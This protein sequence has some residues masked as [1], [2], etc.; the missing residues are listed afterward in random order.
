MAPNSSAMRVALVLQFSYIGMSIFWN[1]IGIGLF[2]AGMKPLGPVA[3]GQT[4]FLLSAIGLVLWIG[5]QKS[6]WV[7]FA[8]SVLLALGAGSAIY[9]S[10]TGAAALWPSAY[11]RWFGAL[12]NVVGLLAFA[13]AAFV[14]LKTISGKKEKEK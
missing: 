4:V 10:L 1:L 8:M 2:E 11:F 14:S 7:Y 6:I 12:I 5:S 3:N 13:L 9:G